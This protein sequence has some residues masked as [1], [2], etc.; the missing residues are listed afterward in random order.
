[1]IAPAALVGALTVLGDQTL[2]PHAAGR[3]E[4]VARFAIFLGAT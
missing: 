2:E 1:M 3:I 4:K